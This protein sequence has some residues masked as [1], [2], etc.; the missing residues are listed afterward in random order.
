MNMPVY[1]NRD[2]KSDSGR[3]ADKNPWSDL[4]EEIARGTE[5]I[6]WASLITIAADFAT[7]AWYP[8]LFV[9]PVTSRGSANSESIAS[10]ETTRRPTEFSPAGIVQMIILITYV[11]I[12]VLSILSRDARMT[13]QLTTTFGQ[14]APPSTGA[15]HAIPLVLAAIPFVFV[16]WM[17]PVLRVPLLL[18]KIIE[19]AGLTLWVSAMLRNRV[20]IDYV[21]TQRAKS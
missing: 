11:S 15:R 21:K 6:Y 1:H 12:A 20:D 16:W 2:H 5:W 4:T 17:A 13:E 19:S 14:Q 18:L 9:A 8:D 7:V 3:A 10:T